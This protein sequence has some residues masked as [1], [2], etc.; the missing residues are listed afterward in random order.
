MGFPALL[1]VVGEVALLCLLCNV[2]SIPIENDMALNCGGDG[3]GC[4]FNYYQ[5]VASLFW[6]GGM[7]CLVRF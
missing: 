4:T 5:G 1:F 2:E 6:C 7:K 3:R